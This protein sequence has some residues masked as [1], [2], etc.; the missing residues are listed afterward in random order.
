MSNGINHFLNDVVNT[1]VAAPKKRAIAEPASAIR[2]A[3]LDAPLTEEE[4]NLVYET[5]AEG[6]GSLEAAYRIAD[7]RGVRFDLQ[8]LTDNDMTN[9]RALAAFEDEQG[10]T[11]EFRLAMAV[12]GVEDRIHCEFDE[13]A[14]HIQAAFSSTAQLNKVTK[15]QKVVTGLTSYAYIRSRLWKDGFR[16]PNK[17]FHDIV[18]TTLLGH[19]IAN[20]VHRI[21][22]EHLDSLTNEPIADDI[23]SQLAP[24]MKTVIGFQPR[25]IAGKED[26]SNHV[27]GLAIDIN[28]T[29]SPH[30]KSQSTIE[31][32]RRHTD[33]P[34]DFGKPFLNPGESIDDIDAKLARASDQILRWLAVALPKQTQLESRVR[35]AEARTGE[36]DNTLWNAQTEAEK[37]AAWDELN[38]TRAELDK[39]RNDLNASS[40]AFEVNELI[41]E[42]GRATLENW[43]RVGLFTIPIELAKQLKERGFGWGAEWSTHK[44]V[45]HFEL[46]PRLLDIERSGDFPLQG[47]GS[48]P[49]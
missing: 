6:F 28:A 19:P 40:D 37:I 14:Q 24:R 18:E 33:P 45:M 38:R 22:V 21:L 27:Y 10:D 12:C 30:I 41:K 16:D 46:D 20:G 44:D 9:P 7:S 48:V 5:I 1:F 35:A 23:H 15:F 42:W 36:A 8:G 31:I 43:Q 4:E 49:G 34:I 26:L 32:I 3:P 13:F 47:N 29:W 2:A 11:P 17:L 25:R 39:A